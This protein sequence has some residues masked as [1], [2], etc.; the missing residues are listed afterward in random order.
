[1]ARNSSRTMEICS[2][3][4]CKTVA[5]ACQSFHDALVLYLVVSSRAE[6]DETVTLKDALG[7]DTPFTHF[8]Q[9]GKTPHM[10]LLMLVLVSLSLDHFPPSTT[11]EMPQLVFRSTVLLLC[12]ID[13]C[14]IPSQGN[15][16]MPGLFSRCFSAQSICQSCT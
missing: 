11:I 8:A 14:S 4:N 5:L 10:Y 7:L 9:P 15:K 6:T 1:M 12:Q 13:P 16:G 3:M 2:R